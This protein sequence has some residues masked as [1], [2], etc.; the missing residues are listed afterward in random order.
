[1]SCKYLVTPAV[2]LSKSKPTF[3]DSSKYFMILI[4]YDMTDTIDMNRH[5]SYLNSNMPFNKYN[6]CPREVKAQLL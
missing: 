3:L 5:K 2:H 6:N 1:M 4:S